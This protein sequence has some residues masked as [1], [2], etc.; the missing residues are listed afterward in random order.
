MIFGHKHKNNWVVALASGGNLRRLFLLFSGFALLF[1][2]LGY[3]TSTHFYTHIH[4]V[5]DVK[6]VHSHPYS[7]EDHTHSADELFSIA[8]QGSFVQLDDV[9]FAFE[10]L[11]STFVSLFVVALS[12]WCISIFGGSARLFRGPPVCSIA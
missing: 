8:A 3:W 5:D 12:S 11:L 2:F 6:V 9:C 1:L 4:I 10:G 7:D